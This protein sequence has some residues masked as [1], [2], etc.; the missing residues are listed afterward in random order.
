MLLLLFIDIDIDIEDTQLSDILVKG[1]EITNLPVR[2]VW[3]KML[4]LVFY[5]IRIIEQVKGVSY[6]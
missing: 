5:D 4:L 1:E 6:I 2:L 3:K